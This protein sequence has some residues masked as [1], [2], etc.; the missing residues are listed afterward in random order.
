MEWTNP[1]YRENQSGQSDNI[2][3][4]VK[5]SW[6][7]ATQRMGEIFASYTSDKGLITRIYKELK[8]LNPSKTNDPLKKWATEICQRKKSK[9]LKKRHE[10]N[11]HHP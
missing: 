4:Y 7:E 8:K 1:A 11:A 2:L 10:K 3:A 6:K 5:R 9:W